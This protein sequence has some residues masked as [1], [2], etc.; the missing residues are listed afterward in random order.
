MSVSVPQIF[1]VFKYLKADY[2]QS[3]HYDSNHSVLQ[4]V[5]ANGL[6]FRSM[7]LRYSHKKVKMVKTSV[8]INLYSIQLV[9]LKVR[10]L[11][12][13]AAMLVCLTPLPFYFLQFV[14]R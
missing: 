8:L 14:F 3:W 2:L 5:T 10:V 13:H 11:W 7:S 6:D 9:R 12:A 1:Q 4:Y